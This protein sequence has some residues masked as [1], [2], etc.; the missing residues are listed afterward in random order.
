MKGTARLPPLILQVTPAVELEAEIQAEAEMNIP[1][2]F[3]AG[4]INLKMGI[5]FTQIL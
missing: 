2:A 3:A 1:A 5:Y 4:I